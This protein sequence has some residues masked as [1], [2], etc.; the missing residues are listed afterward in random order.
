MATKK[1]PKHNTI[2]W[3][4]CDTTTT[5]IYC[6]QNFKL[7][8]PFQ[9]T[10]WQYLLKLYTLIVY[11]P[12][13]LLLGIYPTEIWHMFSKNVRMFILIII[14]VNNS[15]W[16]QYKC[17]SMVEWENKLWYNSYNNIFHISVKMNK[18]LLNATNRWT[19]KT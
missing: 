17:P 4:G 3:H 1:T 14:I 10:P 18:L 2:C 5:L 19:S 15:D 11:C 9:K 6:G 16:K 8:Q 7:V 13:I 12:A